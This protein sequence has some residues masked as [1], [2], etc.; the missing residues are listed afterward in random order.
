MKSIV[1]FVV[2]CSFV[3]CVGDAPP[4]EDPPPA[5]PT[6]PQDG[7]DTTPDAAD[8]IA[9]CNSVTSV[10]LYSESTNEFT[11]PNAFAA[12]ADRCTQYYVYLPA[13]AGDKTQV[14]AD[15]DKVHLLGPNF[16]AM[17]EFHWGA[18]REWVLASPGTPD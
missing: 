6:D 5:G 18:W 1:A 11:L 15:A 4:D 14:R 13:L 2:T 3:G 17:A 8:A 7:I 9:N 12:A 10:V 16:H